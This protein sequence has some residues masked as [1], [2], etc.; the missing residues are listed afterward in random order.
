MAYNII[1]YEKEN[2][3]SD[4]LDF[5]EMLRKKGAGSKDAR[6]QYKQMAFYIELLQ[7]NGTLLPENITKHIDDDIW[8]LR[9][10]NNRIFYFYAEANTFVLLHTFRKRTQKTPKREIERAKAERDDYLSRKENG[11]L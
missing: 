2:G 8:E 1:F 3:E 9:P 10:G 4:V 6:I 7:N 5:L 11:Q